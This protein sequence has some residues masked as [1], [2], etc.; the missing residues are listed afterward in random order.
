MPLGDAQHCPSQYEIDRGGNQRNRETDPDLLDR[1]GGQQ[2]LERIPDDRD[3]GDQDEGTLDGR[4]KEFDLLV[5]I[6]VAAIDRL[7]GIPEREE[8]GERR[9]Q[10]DQ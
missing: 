2:A 4:G 8:R 5:S 9:D 1:L 6:V 10:I 7:G 3:R